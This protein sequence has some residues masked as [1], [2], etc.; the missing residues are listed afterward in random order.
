MTR[1]HQDRTRT[2]DKNEP[3]Y[4]AIQ[5]LTVTWDDVA[6]LAIKNTN[7][8][9]LSNTRHVL[10]VSPPFNAAE[11]AEPATERTDGRYP[12]D[13]TAPFTLNPKDLIEPST[14]RAPPTYDEVRGRTKAAVSDPDEPFD[15]LVDEAWEIGQDVWVA[16]ARDCRR[17]E[18]IIPEP[19]GHTISI[20]WK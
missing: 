2:D 14:V 20:N 4:T 12:E 1:Y 10:S 16:D 8:G 17:D 18:F 3:P 5:E 13:T 6:E 7:R 9:P 19:V 11:T 15:E